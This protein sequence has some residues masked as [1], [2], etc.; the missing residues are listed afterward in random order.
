[1]LA[2]VVLGA[3]FAF[4]VAGATFAT[5]AAEPN[6]TGEG[7]VDQAAATAEGQRL[8]LQH[9]SSCHGPTGAGSARGPAITD[10]GLASWDFMLRTGRMPAATSTEPTAGGQPYFDEAGLEALLAYAGTIVRSGPG[11][12]A[13]TV[14]AAL[15]PRGWEA[16]IQ[17]CAACHAATGAGDAVGG[18]FI[19]PSLLGAEP[20]TIGEAILVG[21]GAMPVFPF[22]ED[23]LDALAT[24]VTSLQGAG[25]GGI[26]LGGLGPVAEGFVAVVVGLGA[27]VLIA[28]FVARTGR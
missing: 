8:Y 28:G 20:R 19:A 14:D 1:L 5:G 27:L 4:T 23:D 24:Y 7:T 16:Y 26:S 22:L 13:V 3:A 6:R 9:C 21:P 2:L 25:R 11:I 10:V 17:N 18:G 12:P 15:L